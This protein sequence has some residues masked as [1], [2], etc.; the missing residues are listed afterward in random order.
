MGG[1]LPAGEYRV[2]M[3]TDSGAFITPAGVKLDGDFNGDAG[4]DYNVRFTVPVG[5]PA[6]PVSLD[7]TAPDDLLQTAQSW[8]TLYGGWGGAMSAALG[9]LANPRRR[10][11]RAA[12]H[13]DVVL[14]DSCDGN[15]LDFAVQDVVPSSMATSAGLAKTSANNWEIR[16]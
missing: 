3:L 12:A 14:Q 4:G 9:P 11:S 15:E 13:A 8:G 5:V 16:L 7:D 6:E 10:R 1:D 2:R